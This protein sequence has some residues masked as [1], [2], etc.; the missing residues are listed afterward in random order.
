[1]I[2]S[3]TGYGKA[4]VSV[5][6]KKVSIE[7]TSVNNRFLELSLRLP[8]VFA[9]YESDLRE[10]ITGMVSRGKLSVLVTMEDNNVSPQTLILNEENAALYYKMFADL[11]KKFKLAGEI[12][13][14]DFTGL[15][16]LFNVAAAAALSKEEVAKLV[17]GVKHAVESLNKMRQREGK[18][19]GDDM[20]MRV[21]L[22]S[23]AIDKI[24]KI[25]PQTVTRYRQRFQETLKKLLDDSTTRSA[26]ETRLRLDMELAL[27]VDKADI[28]EECVRLRSHCDA[29][30]AAIKAEGDTGKR[31]NFILQ[32]MN[33]EA[34][35]IGSKAALYEISA[36]VI[37]IREEIEKLREQ[38][39]NIE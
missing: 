32:E 13:L 8:R 34:N 29:F 20:I 37:R 38:V 26:D 3:M 9:E 21:K 1:M 31:L 36:E 4:A 35:T 2:R 39:Q 12:S 14:A 28:T 23:K 27:L 22:I 17:D 18:A 5:N 11:K 16:E 25:Y 30:A 33:R 10:A 6:K 19:L 24:E 7:I 15:P